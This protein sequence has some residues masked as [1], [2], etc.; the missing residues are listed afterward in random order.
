MN[1]DVSLFRH[2]GLNARA[3][4]WGP[5]HE[6]Y[7]TAIRKAVQSRRMVGIVGG[8]GSGKSTLV[9]QAL[10]ELDKTRTVFI[11]TPDR[12]NLSISNIQTAVIEELSEEAPRRDRIARTI[13]FS[14]IV[15]EKVR[16]H[17]LEVVLVI[18]NAHR[19]H[20]NTL[21]ALKDLRESAAFRGEPFLFSTILVGQEMLATKLSR[22]GEVKY[23][24]LQMRLDDEYW[25]G[26][27]DRINYLS[28]IYGRM[29]SDDARRRI[30]VLF[31]TPLEMDFFVD[32]QM[33]AM[34]ETGERELTMERIPA[35]LGDMKKMLRVSLRDIERITGI[36]KTTIGEIIQGKREDQE[37]EDL[38]RGA[39]DEIA[40]ERSGAP[41][42]RVAT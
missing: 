2:F 14:R 34:Y 3:L 20:A 35:D 30:A 40:D 28:V 32:E 4:Y 31:N 9:R 24:M 10:A 11:N 15:G 41:L 6:K 1:R 37:K 17:G 23:R 21:L 33:Q 39:L 25:M 27:S 13:Q 7:A 29:I 38:I 18:E 8:F 16:I 26:V 36:S 5:G 19:M 42:R 12:E 22:F